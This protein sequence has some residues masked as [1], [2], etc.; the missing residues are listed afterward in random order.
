MP[1]AVEGF[2]KTSTGDVSFFEVRVLVKKVEAM[3]RQIF[4]GEV[5][6]A[7]KEDSEVPDDRHFTF[8]VVD[9][10]NVDTIL[11]RNNEWHRRLCEMPAGVHS[12]FR[13]SIDAQ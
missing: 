6:Y 1:L 2:Y 9:H 5:T 8:N 4:S 13:L 12:L 11:M 3:T 10:G 7:E